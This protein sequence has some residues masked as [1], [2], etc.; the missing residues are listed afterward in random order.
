MS[1]FD[2]SQRQ[3]LG[4]NPDLHRCG[5]TPAR[6]VEIGKH[7]LVEESSTSDGA[8][9]AIAGFERLM[10][11]A[12]HHLATA[13]TSDEATVVRLAAIELWRCIT[14][15]AGQLERIPRDARKARQRELETLER[16]STPVLFE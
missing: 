2:R 12:R 3:R 10:R 8:V 5:R 6:A 16:Q 9:R 11:E 13:S 1:E 15:A 7:T 14:A 4:A